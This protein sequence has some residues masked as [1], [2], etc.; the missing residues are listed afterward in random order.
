MILKVICLPLFIAAV[1]LSGCRTRQE[2]VSLGH[3]GF[4]TNRMVVPVNQTLF[5]AGRQVDLP[6]MRPQVIA[7]SPDGSVLVTSGK[8]HDL[9]LISPSTGKVAQRVPLPSEQDR[10]EDETVSTRI[11][12]PDHEGQASYTGLIFSRDG[13]RI[14]LSNVNGSVKVFGL[15]K[16]NRV[17]GLLTLALPQ[18]GLAQRHAEIPAGLALSQDERKLYVVANLSNRLL[19]LDSKTGALLRAFDVG[20]APYEVV[21][22]KNKAYVSNWGG[23]RPDGQSTVGPAGRGTKV[24]VDPVRFIA[25]EGSVSVVDLDSGKLIKEIVVGLHS[26]ALCLSPDRRLLCVANASSD[27][28]SVIDT[29]SDEVVETISLRW[30]PKDFFGASPNALA[31]DKSGTKLFVCNGTQNA[32][33]VVDFNPGKSRLSGLIPT[34]WYPGAIAYDG[35]HNAIYVANIKGIGSGTDVPKGG[36]AKLN[37]HQSRG[38]LSLISIP[39]RRQLKNYTKTVWRGYQRE[40]MEQALL[41]ARQNIAPCSVPERVGEP[42][43]FK[44]VIYI[45]KENRTYDQVLGDMKE[46]NGDTN[47]CIFGEHVTPNQHKICREF[48]LLDNTRCSGVL[49]ADGHQW[50]DSAFATDYMEKS[51]AGFPRSYPDGMEEGVDA[52][53]YAPSGFIWDNALARGKT[54]RVYGEFANSESGWNEPG[55]KGPPGFADVYADFTQGTSNTFFRSQANLESL[56]PYVKTNTIGWNLHV[57]DLFRARKFIEDL[58]DWERAGDMPNLCILSLP[59]DHTGGTQPGFPTPAAAV[60]DNDLAVG[61]ILEALSH[62]TYWRDTVVFIIEDD[63]QN[64]FDHVSSYRTTA[65]VASAYAR[66]GAVVH[67]LYNQTSLLRTIELILGLPPMNQLDATA[68]PMSDCF[69]NEPDFRPFESVKNNVPLDQLNPP[70]GAIKNPVQKKFA[71][72]SMRL[73][74]DDEDDCPEDTLNRVLWFAQKGEVPYPVWA[75]TESSKGAN[76]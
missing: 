73:P 58:H 28:V 72:I 60:A 29:G 44:H 21:I 2:D 46:G 55:H 63:P 27:S 54:L 18:S 74:L 76:D 38:T 67:T 20:V 59:N 71:K 25:S 64:G 70:V 9:V 66:R 3:S 1:V 62:S 17:E 22:F 5:P 14:F 40:V 4:V 57:L 61:Q 30:H 65:Y 41:P 48:V 47:L 52:L 8:T 34:G 49:S 42:S 53:A 68:T 15:G 19:E 39:T 75:V 16:N 36:K 69:T 56:R 35:K 7:L 37:S 23:R 6:D 43:V 51:F 50:A 31:F 26:T 13:K 45:I 33:A 24:R 10:E 12:K 11:L 32:V